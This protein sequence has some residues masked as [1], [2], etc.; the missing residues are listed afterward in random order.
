MFLTVLCDNNTFIDNYLLGEPALS[1]YIE[2]GS[3]KILFDTG[4]SDVYVKNAKTMEIDLSKVN[5][6]VLSHGHDD[7]TKGLK[8]HK[9]DKSVKLYCCEG[10]FE[11]SFATMLTYLR[12]FQKKKY[13]RFLTLLNLKSQP[14]FLRTCMFW[15][16]YQG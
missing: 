7:H 2:N 1:F 10:C 8:Y 15:G 6:I 14:R 5:K 12:H 9:F 4:Y 3:D 16:K 11:K 13:P